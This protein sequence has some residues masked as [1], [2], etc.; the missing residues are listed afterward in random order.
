MTKP[1]SK[2]WLP[3]RVAVASIAFAFV[4]LSVA[5]SIAGCGGYCEARQVR[6][7]CHQAVGSQDLKVHQR[8]AEFQKCKANPLSYLGPS[9]RG[10]AQIGSD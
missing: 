5:Q 1:R 7:I 8:D 10:D 3:H 2:R 9:V 4:L 6:A